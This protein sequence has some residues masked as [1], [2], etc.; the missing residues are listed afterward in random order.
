MKYLMDNS[1][2]PKNKQKPIALY[3]SECDLEAF[4][5]LAEIKDNIV[6]FVEEG[7]NLYICS[8]INGNGKSSWSLKLLMKYFDQVWDGNGFVARGVII[9]VPTFFIKCKDFKNDDEEFEEL[10][11]RLL[12]VDL[13]VWDDIAGV[14]MS[15][16]DYSQLLVYLDAREFN[17]LSN[18]YTSNITNRATLANALGEKITSRVWNSNTEIVEFK[19]G[20]RR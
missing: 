2:I 5:R 15:N 18:I 13:V 11:K 19:G 4:Q 1:N 14:A 7:K 10:K 3:P 20:D 17:G 8:S 9:H 6:D 16:Y 12:E